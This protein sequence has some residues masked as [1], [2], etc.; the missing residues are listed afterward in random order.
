MNL[1]STRRLNEIHAAEGMRAASE[2]TG[3]RA[4]QGAELIKIENNVN[5]IA[6]QAVQ[7]QSPK[8]KTLSLTYIPSPFAVK[9][10]YERGDIQ[11]GVQENKPIIESQ[12]NKPEIIAHRGS[13]NISME[14][15]AELHIDFDNLYV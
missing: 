9:L 10:H 7:N 6:E 12:I 13:V 1:M 4:E 14:Q 3:R 11:I 2:G 15:Y 5:V 8:M